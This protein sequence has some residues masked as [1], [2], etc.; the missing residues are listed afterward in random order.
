MLFSNIN[1]C[2][3]EYE[4]QKYKETLPNVKPESFLSVFI[5]LFFLPLTLREKKK[6]KRNQ[7]FEGRCL[8]TYATW[9]VEMGFINEAAVNMQIKFN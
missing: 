5:I 2:T 7:C 9:I 6:W 1:T 3:Y 8:H 4:T